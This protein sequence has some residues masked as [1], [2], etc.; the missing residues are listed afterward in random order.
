MK[1]TCLQLKRRG[2]GQWLRSESTW[3]SLAILRS[4]HRQIFSWA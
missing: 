3:S 1:Q 2:G 4:G